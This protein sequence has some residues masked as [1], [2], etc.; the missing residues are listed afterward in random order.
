MPPFLK[1]MNETQKK[2]KRFC[3]SNKITSPIEYRVLDLVSEIGELV[4]EILIMSDYG[5]NT[6]E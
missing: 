3:K 4:K 5:Q 1:I 6:L 2:V